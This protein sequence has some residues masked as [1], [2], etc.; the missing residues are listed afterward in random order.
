MQIHRVQLS[1]TVFVRGFAVPGSVILG[2]QSAGHRRAKWHSC[3]VAEDDVV[4][5]DGRKEIDLQFT[6]ASEVIAIS[7]DRQLLDRHVE[8]ICGK[9][10]K[11]DP[12]HDRLKIASP[13][14]VAVLV[15]SWTELTDASLTFGTQLTDANIAAQLETKIV[16]AV[17]TNIV[18]A[19]S[20]WGV[21][22]RRRIAERARRYMVQNIRQSM[23][24]TDIC[25]AVGTT[26]RTLH[27]GFREC[28]DT[29]PKKFLKLLR[30]NAAR[31]E[32]QHPEND[33]CVT[34]VALRWGFFHLAR[35]AAEY[36][37]LFGES[38]SHTLRRVLG[39]T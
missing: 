22:E 2:I 6:G 24:I 11:I 34:T 7:I 17:F 37:G 36:R 8:A 35:F 23:T 25:T 18:H 32:L 13:E 30:L 27:L 10:P 39:T 31:R 15:R 9:A 14:K 1:P 3:P 4:M 21:T 20:E 38:P 28:F 29:T 5:F 33:T 16:E 12:A 19:A 26:E